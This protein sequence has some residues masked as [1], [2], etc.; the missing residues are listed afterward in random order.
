[1]KERIT[2]ELD[3]ESIAAARE[4]GIDLSELLVTALRRLLPNLHAKEREAL[5]RQW[6]EEN[7]T[8][9]ESVNKSIEEHGLWSD[10][11][12]NF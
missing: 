5:A 10:G 1:M 11:I 4:A 3:S 2:L 6:Q 12:R 9:L 8:A 7:K